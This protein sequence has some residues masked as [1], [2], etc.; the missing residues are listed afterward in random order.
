VQQR[1]RAT[2]QRI[3]LGRPYRAHVADARRAEVRLHQASEVVLVLHDPGDDQRQTGLLCDRNRPV[4]ALVGMDAAQEQQVVPGLI[5]EGER[6]EVDAVVD[7][8]VV[9]QVRVPVRIA[10]RHVVRD[11]VVGAVDRQDPL[12]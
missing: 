12:R 4:G 7:R 5:P 1:Q 2:E 11:V 10:D 6:G 3:P 9:G 8:R